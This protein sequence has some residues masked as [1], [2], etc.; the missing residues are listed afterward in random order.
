MDVSD[1]DILQ[2]PLFKRRYYFFIIGVMVQNLR[3]L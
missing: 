3:F 2:W 1:D